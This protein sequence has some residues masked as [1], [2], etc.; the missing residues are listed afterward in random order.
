MFSEMAVAVASFGEVGGDVEVAAYE[1]VVERFQAAAR[2]FDGARQ[3]R[4]TAGASILSAVQRV[5]PVCTLPE[6]DYF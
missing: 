3:R 1:C 2:A 4:A 6:A 5:L